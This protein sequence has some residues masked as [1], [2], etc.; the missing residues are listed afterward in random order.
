MAMESRGGAGADNE[1]KSMRITGI[2]KTTT[3]ADKETTTTGG[4]KTVTT[5]EIDATRLIGSGTISFRVV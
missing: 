2:A 5:A 1:I 4:R 3:D